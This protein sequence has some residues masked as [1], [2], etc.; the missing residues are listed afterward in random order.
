MTGR[1]NHVDRPP[2]GGLYKI[3]KA[4]RVPRGTRLR[5]LRG[6][7]RGRLPLVSKCRSALVCNSPPAGQRLGQLTD[8]PHKLLI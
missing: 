3:A 6:L 5:P 4:G 7:R 1:L 2:K 8:K